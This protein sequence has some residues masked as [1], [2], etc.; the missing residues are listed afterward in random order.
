MATR[1]RAGRTVISKAASFELSA[2]LTIRVGKEPKY[3]D[4]IAHESF[5]TERSPFFHCAMKGRWE[6]SNTR[7]I[8]F[9]D[10]QHT[11][12]ALYLN[13]VYTGQLVT[14]RRCEE[15]G[16]DFTYEDVWD[17]YDDLFRLYILAEKLQDVKTKNAVIAAAIDTTRTR[18]KNG[19]YTIPQSNII[20][21]VYEGTPIG[22][23][24]RRL[25]TDMYSIVPMTW[26]I[27]HL[28]ST[29]MH[30]DFLVDL[31]VAL[32]EI[33]P[34]KAEHKGNIVERNGAE[35]YMEQI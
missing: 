27:S 22:S 10:D 2:M 18:T 3:K 1:A 6:E 5:L 11:I 28:Q 32:S 9:P 15:E 17:E 7:I 23:P 31:E 14:M 19:K 4:F 30:G 8:K 20:N 25:I 26:I 33:R 12:F 24:A 21:I 35:S 16:S 29:P 34:I 13:F